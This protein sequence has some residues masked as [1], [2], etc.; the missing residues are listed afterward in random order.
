MSHCNEPSV[1]ICVPLWSGQLREY[2]RNRH[3]TAA[4]IYE[5]VFLI[6][7]SSRLEGSQ[8]HEHI[9]DREQEGR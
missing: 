3:F 1:P 2:E 5:M 6:K 8:K 7:G 4:H 9:C